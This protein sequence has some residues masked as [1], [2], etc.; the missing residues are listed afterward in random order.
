MKTLIDKPLILRPYETYKK[1]FEPIEFYG[2]NTNRI[3]MNKLLEEAKIK[4]QLI[5]S[6]SDGKYK[7]PTNIRRWNPVWEFFQNHM[8]AVI[9]PVKF[10]YKDT[11]L[12]GNIKYVLEIIGENDKEE[13]VPIHP[14][15]YEI[16]K[17]RNFNFNKQALESKEALEQYLEV[18]I[19][20]GKLSCKKYVVHDLKEWR[21]RVHEFYNGKTI[22]AKY[23]NWFQYRV[24]G[25]IGT[26]YSDWKLKKE[27]AKLQRTYEIRSKSSSDT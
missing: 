25:K 8:T 26:K 21:E 10:T 9:R 7:V 19:Q 15:D 16:K 3:N 17:F 24:L 18:Q 6:T 13:I 11:G 20:Q 1:E 22:D 23:L 2:I 12:G 27:N 14:R 4:K 5:L